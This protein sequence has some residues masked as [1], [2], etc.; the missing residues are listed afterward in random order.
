MS[1]QIEAEVLEDL[2]KI[3]IKLSKFEEVELAYSEYGPFVPDIDNAEDDE[4]YLD[5]D[6]KVKSDTK[7]R[8]TWNDNE[9]K[10]KEQYDNYK[11]SAI[12]TILNLVVSRDK[13]SLQDTTNI[14]TQYYNSN[15]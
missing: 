1:K 12:K 7:Y 10:F 14:L 13:S 11:L 3:L 15:C 5:E 4:K 8:D 6:G 2:N 9:V